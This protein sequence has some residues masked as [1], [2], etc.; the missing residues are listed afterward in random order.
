MTPLELMEAPVQEKTRKPIVPKPK[1]DAL[2]KCFDAVEDYTSGQIN[3]REFHAI[4]K[5]YGFTQDSLN[6]AYLKTAAYETVFEG[7][8]QGKY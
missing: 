7:V 4:L 1:V 6:K 2:E 5:S 3:T 8:D